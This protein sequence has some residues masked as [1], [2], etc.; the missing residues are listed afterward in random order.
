VYRELGVVDAVRFLGQFTTGFGNYAEEREA[1]FA[2]K[3]LGDIV[4]EIE[5]PKRKPAQHC[6]KLTASVGC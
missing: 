2:K 1:L 5:E 6:T 4:T 3:S